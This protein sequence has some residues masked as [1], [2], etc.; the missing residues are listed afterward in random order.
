VKRLVPALGVLLAGAL[1]GCENRYE[2]L[3]A[4]PPGLTASLDDDGKTIRLSKG[5]SIGFECFDG[6]SREPC[7]RDASS[8][9]QGTALIFPA[10][11]DTVTEYDYQH[12]PQ[13]RSAFVVVGIA[14]GRT[15]V[16][17]GGGSLAVTVLSAD[18]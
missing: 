12:G 11:L 5:V 7:S 13:T 4:P 6:A 17:A 1:V 14:E 16:Q 15:E 9:D 2:A 10:S 8:D 18:R 3:T